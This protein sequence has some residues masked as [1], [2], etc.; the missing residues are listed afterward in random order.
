MLSQYDLLSTLNLITLMK[1]LGSNL[2]CKYVLQS[3]L[4]SADHGDA[5]ILPRIPR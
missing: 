5:L 2:G 3:M 1:L 4:I